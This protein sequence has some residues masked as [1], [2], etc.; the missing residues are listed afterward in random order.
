MDIQPFSISISDAALDDLHDRL[1]RT[2]W[3]NCIAD[4]GWN[5][6]TDADFLKRLVDYWRDEF[7]WRAQESRL[8]TLPHYRAIIAEHTIHFIHQPGKGPRPLAPGTDPWLARF[9]YRN[10]GHH[11]LA[12]RSGQPCPHDA[13]HVVVPSLPGYGFF[14]RAR[15]QGHRAV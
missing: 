3:Q 1:S 13:F 12:R 10:G 4:T 8:N 6:G 11:P 7:D 5:E 2:R 9:L 15:H 14:L